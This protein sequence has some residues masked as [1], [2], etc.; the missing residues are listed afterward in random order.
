M[1]SPKY[2]TG[3]KLEIKAFIDKFDVSL[4]FS[5]LSHHAARFDVIFF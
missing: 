5:R 4:V 1:S 2:I 3:D